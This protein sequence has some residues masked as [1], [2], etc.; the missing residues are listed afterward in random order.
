MIVI[1]LHG[2]GF[3]VGS[4]DMIPVIQIQ[5]LV[6]EFGFVAVVP[7]YRLCP[8][9]SLYEGPVTDTRDC[10]VWIQEKLPGL[11][12]Q[13]DVNV[14]VQPEEVVAMG[15]S[16]GGTLALLLVSLLLFFHTLLNCVVFG[17]RRLLMR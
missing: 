1:I 10:F 9:V 16:A 14:L 11:L 17:K 5:T 15:Y 3:V 13:D 8:T 4:K 2:G 12:E 7:N 6:Q